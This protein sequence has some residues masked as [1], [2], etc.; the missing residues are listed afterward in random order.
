MP[1]NPHIVG[2]IEESR[3]DTRLVADD[4]LQKSSIAT[5]APSHPGISEN[6]DIARL[7]LWCRR[8][9]RDDLVVRIVDRR[10]NHIDLAGRE[11]GQSGVDIDIERREFAQFQLQDFQIPAGIERDLII[12]DPERSLLGLRYSGQDDSRDLSKSHRA[13]GLKPAM[14]RDDMAFGIS[15][16]WICEPKRFD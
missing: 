15:E 7:R 2:R 1:P 16:N 10:E 8:N 9:G 11:A 13:R 3:I 14:T 12:G 6:P 5:I 4:P